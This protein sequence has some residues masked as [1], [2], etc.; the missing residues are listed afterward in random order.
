MSFSGTWV[1]QLIKLPILDFGS[2]QDLRAMRSSHMW[3]SVLSQESACPS[4]LLFLLSLSL[5]K[6]IKSLNEKKVFHKY[7]KRIG[8]NLTNYF[9]IVDHNN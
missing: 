6:I 9:I 3:G 7:L 5:S 2:D 4:P 1:G 8:T